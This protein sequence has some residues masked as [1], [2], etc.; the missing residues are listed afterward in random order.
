MNHTVS[1]LASGAISMTEQRYR[2]ADD[3][4]EEFRRRLHD[5]I[6][7]A[8]RQLRDEAGDEI[9]LAMAEPARPATSGG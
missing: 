9:A 4:E 6:V 3:E 7:W 8:L 1:D 2:P 5:L